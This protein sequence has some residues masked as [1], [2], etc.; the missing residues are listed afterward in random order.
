MK[1]LALS[2][3]YPPHYEGGYELICE[4]MVA[5]LRERGHAVQVLTS[6]H[7]TSGT[8]APEPEVERSMRI[9]GFF[10]HPWR[11]I[12][13]LR[14]LERH[15]NQ[16]LRAAV[17]RFAPDVV[18]IWNM[19]GLSKSMLLTL[20]QIGVPVTFYVSDHWIGRSLSADVWLRWWNRNDAGPLQRMLRAFWEM[21]G[22]RR[23]WQSIAP[24]N[25]LRHVRFQRA[26]FC[27]RSLRDLTGA[28]GYDV[29]H[30]AV[31]YS[32]V[33][34]ERFHGLPRT[35]SQPIRR[36]LFAG[37]LG[38][39][40]GVM[41]ALRA[42]ALLKDKFA[43][44]LT[45]CGRGSAEY[46]AELKRFAADQQLPVTFTSAGA[47][48][49]PEVYR[50]HDALLFT[51]EW[52][53]PFALTPL[54]AMASGLPVIATTTGGSAELFRHLENALTYTAGSAEDLSRRILDLA[55][56][57]S[58]RATIAAAG[59]REVRERYTAAVIATR[60]EDYLRET[61]DSWRPAPL[62]QYADLT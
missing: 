37:R 50:T 54:E 25:P 52:A 12:L 13:G 34:I 27:S 44:E 18:H 31:I 2:N 40:K 7:G 6:S 32:P 15:N 4:R 56:D 11:G 3:L 35:A 58:L 5:A 41:T 16:V 1:I 28:A 43:G 61:I 19:G 22:V 39:D 42:M 21:I 14:V 17:E 9:H 59:H 47:E 23:R 48:E 10:G 46:T 36:L 55:G 26:S 30:C 45:I 8:D 57:D 20:Q 62:P 60:I 24:T 51:S 38:E 29:A 53:E 49:M 33:N